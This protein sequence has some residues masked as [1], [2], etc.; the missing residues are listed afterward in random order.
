MKGSTNNPLPQAGGPPDPRPNKSRPSACLVATV[1]T[2]S[3]VILLGLGVIA[4]AGSILFP[5]ISAARRTARAATCR[6]RARQLS[7][8]ILMYAFDHDD[9]LPLAGNWSDAVIGHESSRAM[10]KLWICPATGSQPGYAFYAP[11]GGRSVQAMSEHELSTTP[12]LFE[13]T[14]RGW[15]ATAPLTALEARHDWKGQ[16]GGWVVWTLGNVSLEAGPL[17][18]PGIPA[19][20]PTATSPRIQPLGNPEFSLL[21]VPGQR[22]EGGA[23]P[24]PGPPFPSGP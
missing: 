17:S 9:R 22:G 2:A 1:V 18:A 3:V 21:P 10:R 14:T 7:A 8:A 20:T 12:M 4:V 19:S 6:S 16:K 15:N 23:V 11:L 24:K 13:A 5:A